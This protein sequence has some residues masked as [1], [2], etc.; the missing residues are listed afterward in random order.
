M[1]IKNMKK[2][3]IAVLAVSMMVLMCGFYAAASETE[4]GGYPYLQEDGQIDLVGYF[5][6]DGVDISLSEN[7]MDFVMNQEQATIRFKKALA[8]D[9]F[10]LKFSGVEGSKF[11]KIEY[12][13]TDAEN[14][15][16]SIK[17]V[18]F[19]MSDSQTAVSVN[20]GGRS[21]LIA[22]S[23]NTENDND[24]SVGYNADSRCINNGSELSVRVKANQDESAFRGFSSQ[25]VTLSVALYGDA[26]STFRLTELNYQRFGTN[27]TEDK[28][29]PMVCVTNPVNYAIKG[30]VI[31][32]ET[33]FATDVLADHAAVTITVKDPERSIVTAE[34]GTKLENVTPDRNYYIKI[35][36]YGDYWIE[37]SA[38][39]GKNKTHMLGRQIRVLDVAAPKFTLSETMK[40]LWQVGDTVVFP[41]MSCS[42][43]RTEEEDMVCWITVKHPDGVVTTE[44]NE[45]QLTE[46][47]IYEISFM[48]MDETGNIS[49]VTE[50]ICAEEKDNEK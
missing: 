21:Y 19:Y 26:G 48:A 8:A 6:T 5:E 4:A 17:V 20:E 39:D 23:L 18:Y 30:A 44:K 34:D 35:A 29:E 46:K 42:D 2:R 45:L 27:Y 24:F 33:A 41:Q 49:S 3:I 31:P 43:N 10:L 7:N 50:K 28:T 40:V 38:T 25:T 47:G 13:L 15:E 37:Y 12:V 32:V 36:D 9:G 11:S 14:P 16:E 1:V 22:G